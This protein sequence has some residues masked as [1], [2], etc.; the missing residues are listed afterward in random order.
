MPMGGKVGTRQAQQNWIGEKIQGRDQIEQ[1]THHARQTTK[2]GANKNPTGTNKPQETNLT[3]AASEQKLAAGRRW[4]NKRKEPTDTLT[5]KPHQTKSQQVEAGSSR[6]QGRAEIPAHPNH[7][8]H[9]NT[10]GT[11]ENDKTH[12]TEPKAGERAR[13]KKKREKRKGH[14]HPHTHTH[15]HS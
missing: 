2:T 15:R 3:K 10:R 11:R 13:E 6:G 9:K 1:C 7:Q 4:Q 5:T 12:H 14:A 8:R